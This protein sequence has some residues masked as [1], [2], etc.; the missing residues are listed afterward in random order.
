MFEADI[1][2]FVDEDREDDDDL[3]GTEQEEVFDNG[4]H[5]IGRIGKS[6]MYWALPSIPS[7]LG[8]DNKT[9]P[10]PP[11]SDSQAK[12]NRPVPDQKKTYVPPARRT[13][14]KAEVPPTVV[15]CSRKYQKYTQKSPVR[16][17][18][19]PASGSWKSRPKR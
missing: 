3:Y 2:S 8:E 17:S 19:S 4:V 16:P 7:M 15:H 6:N 11:S 9:P 14:H 12:E 18:K 5:R 10:A 13:G 1:L